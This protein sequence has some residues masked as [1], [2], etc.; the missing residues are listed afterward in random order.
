MRLVKPNEIDEAGFSAFIA[1]FKNAGES[2]VPY[3]IN[4]KDLDFDSYI[5]SLNDE[6]MG[7]GLRENWVPASTFFLIDDEDEIVGA[8]NIR[9]RLTENLKI[10]GGHIGYGIR[11]SARRR[12]YGTMIL[13]LGLEKLRELEIKD[14]LVTCDKD[15][16]PSAKTI[17][18]NGGRF[19]SETL[20]DGTI[21]LRFWIK[22]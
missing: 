19:H 6:S 18:N 2:L 8:V 12:G 13:E 3:S 11:P 9:H 22:L 10:E 7:I 1:E 21:G 14:V 4:Q 16:I 20:K 15:N 5:K 17:A